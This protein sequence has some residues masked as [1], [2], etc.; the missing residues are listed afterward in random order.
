MGMVELWKNVLLK[1]KQTFENELKEAKGIKEGVKNL[2]VATVIYLLIDTILNLI[3]GSLNIFGMI[4]VLILG[5]IILILLVAF[6]NFVIAGMY[7]L[8]CKFLGAK[9]TNYS[10]FFYLFALLFSVFVSLGI[11]IRIISLIP[12]IGLIAG[13]FSFLLLLY[14]I[15]VTV[16]LIKA[17]TGFGTGKAIL[18]CVIPSIVIVIAFLVVSFLAIL[19]LKF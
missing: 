7:Y 18:A 13:V 11:I 6:A 3:T 16:Q 14:S 4:T 19:L 15:Y 5:S 10:K 17:A 8:T 12:V 2:A 1:P 9:E